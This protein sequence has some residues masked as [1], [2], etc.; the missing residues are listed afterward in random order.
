MHCPKCGFDNLENATMCQECGGVFIRTTPTRTSGRAITSTI[1]GITGFS[2]FGIFVVTSI[3]GLVFDSL[4]LVAWIIS[5]VFG[6]IAFIVWMVGLILGMAAMNKIGKSGGTVKGKGFAIT[7][8]A[9]S[10][11]GMTFLLTVV[12]VML[13]INSMSLR[14]KVEMRQPAAV[15][16]E[17][18]NEPNSPKPQED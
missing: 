1:L 7:G 15:V 10:A 3:F 2:I 14:K 5:L 9:A 4:V 12:G 16:V 17:D 11:T 6:S 13:F 18:N 8:I